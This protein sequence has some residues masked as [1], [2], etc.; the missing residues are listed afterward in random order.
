MYQ[1]EVNLWLK[2]GKIPANWQIFVLVLTI[3]LLKNKTSYLASLDSFCI[4]SKC[5]DVDIFAL[6]NKTK[7]WQIL[8]CYAMHATLN[9]MTELWVKTHLLRFKSFFGILRLAE[10][11]RGPKKLL[12]QHNVAEFNE[13]KSKLQYRQ[14][15]YTSVRNWLL[16]CGSFYLKV[17][18]SCCFP[19]L[20]MWTVGDPP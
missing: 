6:E 12:I 7:Y 19:A 1:K 8:K 5:K 11:L 4:S 9:T 2:K 17:W 3:N 15:V 14:A 13:I 16:Y 10:T 18:T 20:G